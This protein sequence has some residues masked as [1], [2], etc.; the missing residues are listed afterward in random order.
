MILPSS[1]FHDKSLS[2]SVGSGKQYLIVD[3]R[4][5]SRIVECHIPEDDIVSIVTG[6]LDPY[7]ASP[8]SSIV[9]CLGEWILASAATSSV[10][11]ARMDVVRDIG[12]RTILSGLVRRVSLNDR[13]SYQHCISC[14]S[15]ACLCLRLCLLLRGPP[16]FSM[17]IRF[18]SA[19]QNR[20]VAMGRRQKRGA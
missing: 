1:T 2:K 10:P 13:P 11:S 17:L 12:W 15:A 19:G 20:R 9:V 5:L 14:V 18:V 3:T 6:A 4:V 7:A 8:C 16:M